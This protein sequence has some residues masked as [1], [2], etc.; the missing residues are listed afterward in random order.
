MES[1]GKNMGHLY[2]SMRYLGALGTMYLKEFPRHRVVRGDSVRI[3]RGFSVGAWL[4]VNGGRRRIES[5][6]QLVVSKHGCGRLVSREGSPS[7]VAGMRIRNSK[8][9]KYIA[10]YES[11]RTCSS[12]A[13]ET[14][15][16][17]MCDVI[18]LA[19]RVFLPN[20]CGVFFLA[21]LCPRKL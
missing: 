14:L 21:C 18:D 8:D 10:C 15:S 5:R 12:A 4:V 17:S 13:S 3:L 9:I 16:P 7:K 2:R 1:L 6:Y 11:I 20:L 19:H